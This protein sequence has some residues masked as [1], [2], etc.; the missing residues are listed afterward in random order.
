VGFFGKNE[1][2]D[3]LLEEPLLNGNSSERN[4]AIPYKCEGGETVTPY[5][6]ARFFSIITFSWMGPLIAVG[7]KKTL[8]LEDVPQLDP[9]D[10]VVGS[11]PTFKNK[12]EAECGTINRMTTLKLVKAIIYSVWKEILLTAVLVVIYTLASY[13]G[14]Y[15][16]DTF[17]QYLNGRWE[18]KN[19]GYILMSVFFAAK[20]VECLS[21]RH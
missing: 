7:N 1:G 13:V 9:G 10:C 17:V 20:L 18:F 4:E 2:E 5:S 19:E 3:T 8:A 15:R 11:F 16:M 6:N 14:P 12:L 21:Q